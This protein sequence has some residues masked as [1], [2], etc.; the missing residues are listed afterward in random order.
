MCYYTKLLFSIQLYSGRKTGHAD[1]S[2]LNKMFY[3]L[4]L[5][6]LQMFLNKFFYFYRLMLTIN[7][8]IILIL[9]G[10]RYFI[11]LLF[12]QDKHFYFQ[13]N[14]NFTIFQF[15]FDQTKY[16]INNHIPNTSLTIIIYTKLY[17]LH[18]LS[19]F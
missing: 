14:I 4:S 11:I 6:R 3:K 7:Y 18:C 10:I 9:F 19:M 15:S 13:T 2:I 17:K 1:S 5:N 8:Q 16:I 12:I